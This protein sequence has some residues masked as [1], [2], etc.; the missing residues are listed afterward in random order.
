MEAYLLV[1]LPLG[2]CDKFQPCQKNKVM[3]KYYPPE[4]KVRREGKTLT[5]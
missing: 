1:C 4:C 3:V 2:V 5:L